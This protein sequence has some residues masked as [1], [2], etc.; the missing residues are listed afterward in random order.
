LDGP[1]RGSQPVVER[2]YSVLWVGTRRSADA[3]ILQPH[4]EIDLA[5]VGDLEDAL[6]AA[7]ATGV[8]KIV[9]DL[10]AVSMLDSA[11]LRSLVSAYDRAV[12]THRELS[13]RPGS[14]RIRRVF[15][16]SGL[17]DRLPLAG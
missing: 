7:E 5:T 3:V 8:A 1:P 13:I 11:G 10:A 4:G 6:R 17:A 9:I 15:E 2:S 12:E 14:G 16:V